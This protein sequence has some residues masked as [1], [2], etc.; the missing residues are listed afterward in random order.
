MDD[1]TN[2]YPYKATFDVLT[3]VLMKSQVLW[4]VKAVFI[5]NWTEFRQKHTFFFTEY[6]IKFECRVEEEIFINRIQ[7]MILIL[8]ARAL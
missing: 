3:A 4:D 5:F 2:F 6:G 8:N 1:E 7:Y